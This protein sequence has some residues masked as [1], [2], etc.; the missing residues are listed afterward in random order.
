MS[1]AKL[2]PDEIEIN[3]LERQCLWRLRR[4][5][6]P[7]SCL[8]Y[9][10]SRVHANGL[11]FYF[12]CKFLTLKP[13]FERII[14]KYWKPFSI[15]M[16]ENIIVQGFFVWTP[17]DLRDGNIVPVILDPDSYIVRMR[18]DILQEKRE[19]RVFR[20][21][22]AYILQKDRE[23]NAQ[24]DR[25]RI[26]IDCGTGIIDGH[27]MED[28]SVKVVDGFGYDPDL[29]GHLNSILA[30]LF[31]DAC[32][33]NQEK[34]SYQQQQY[35][36]TH[37]VPI[38]Q[39]PALNDSFTNTLFESSVTPETQSR[40]IETAFGDQSRAQAQA[41]LRTKMQF[42][43]HERSRGLQP[44]DG[45][46][47]NYL[48]NILST[49]E[50]IQTATRQPHTENMNFIPTPFGATVPAWQPKTDSKNYNN[51]IDHYRKVCANVFELPI[52]VL[53]TTGKV[54]STAEF[55]DKQI[56]N[57]IMKWSG[58]LSAP[59][60]EVYNIIYAEADTDW[61]N[62]NIITKWLSTKALNKTIEKIQ[63]IDNKE[64]EEKLPPTDLAN[65]KRAVLDKNKRRRNYLTSKNVHSRIISQKDAIDEYNETSSGESS[66][67][68]EVDTRQPK[69]AKKNFYD[70]KKENDLNTI[71]DIIE[72]LQLATE[73]DINIMFDRIETG[74]GN[75]SI[76][77]K[78]LEQMKAIVKKDAHVTITFAQATPLTVKQIYT[79]F[80]S[81][82]MTQH[83]FITALR[84]QANLGTHPD[85]CEYQG[86][87]V[88][89]KE[90]LGALDVEEV[91]ADSE[92]APLAMLTKKQIQKNQKKAVEEAV[93]VN[94]QKNQA[95]L[96]K[97]DAKI[98]QM[99]MQAKP[100]PAAGGSKAKA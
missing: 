72:A 13:D 97:Q 44:I 18:Y 38:V 7:S 53:D 64:T 88:D 23:L 16:L 75:N 71:D 30:M 83:E 26:R 24:H 22:N 61:V 93:A 51:V 28:E 12:G 6:V 55:Q 20:K 65:G 57:C 52:G 40:S 4:D 91:L 84:A 81:G 70:F 58:K 99:K 33:V 89:L 43:A 1:F 39:M 45:V 66:S 47:N 95:K 8:E 46:A 74:D 87:L 80:L 79:Y 29:H 94:E 15:A 73:E 67:D 68:E 69:R 96:M 36:V 9:I 90:V 48:S 37:A 17:V 31:E 5:P 11:H 32:F 100:K 76:K 82:A 77:I 59:L 14:D 34:L 21:A 10:S 19:Y 35:N 50:S 27:I 56:D 3:P 98:Q 25:E 86:I 2:Y 54:V 49:I 63:K 60:T 62:R 92:L 41:H 85:L 78:D 42:L